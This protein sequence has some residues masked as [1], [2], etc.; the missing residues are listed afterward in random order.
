MWE[1]TVC[2]FYNKF[3][4]SIFIKIRKIYKKFEYEYEF[5][6]KEISCHDRPL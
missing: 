6:Y 5:E 4:F 2:L 1:F 3:F